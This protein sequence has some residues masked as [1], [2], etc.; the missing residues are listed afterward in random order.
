VSVA[1]PY[2]RVLAPRI[3]SSHA[4]DRRTV[5]KLLRVAGCSVMFVPPAACVPAP[6]GLEHRHAADRPAVAATH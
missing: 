2:P 5:Q 1:R 4:G 3:A 6:I